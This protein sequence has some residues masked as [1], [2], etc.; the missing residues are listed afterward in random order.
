MIADRISS[1][2]LSVAEPTRAELAGRVSGMVALRAEVASFL[3]KETARWLKTIP[4]PSRKIADRLVNAGGKRIRPMLSFL[5]AGACGGDWGDARPVATAV[6]LL[7]TGTLLHDDVIDRSETRRGLPA[8]HIEW[9]NS[10]AI[11]TGDFCYFAALDALLELRDVTTMEY[12]MGVARALAHG[13]LLQ[14]ERT[15]SPKESFT[16]EECVSIMERKTASLFEFA[17]LAGARASGATSAK[18]D[19]A[20]RFGKKLGLAFQLLDDILDFVGTKEELGKGAGQDIEHGCVTVPMV[21]ADEK[22][23]GILAKLR[24]G[25]LSTE[26]M[27]EVIVESGAL[28][29]AREMAAGFNREAKAALE[30]LPDS[31]ER[32]VLLGIVSELGQ[33]VQ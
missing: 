33:R 21:L 29:G 12:A 17:C 9:D 24:K 1:T 19:A 13:E 25:E 15:R 16:L 30:E 7:H 28:K 3:D 5:S 4:E 2:V 22:Q 10:V 23:P 31:R 11:L 27:T 18:I 32:Q 8:A 20:A 14:L 26:K 6:E